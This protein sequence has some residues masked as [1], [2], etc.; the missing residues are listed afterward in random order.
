MREFISEFIRFDWIEYKRWSPNTKSIIGSSIFLFILLIAFLCIVTI[1]VMGFSSIF[2]ATTFNGEANRNF[3]LAVAALFGAPFLVWRTIVAQTQANAALKQAEA[4]L[5][6]AIAASDQA[7]TAAEQARIAF[8][9]SSATA[10]T[11]AVELLGSYRQVSEYNENDSLVVLHEP[12]LEARIGGVFALEKIIRDNEADARAATETLAAFCRQH[13]KKRPVLQIPRPSSQDCDTALQVLGRRRIPNPG[14][15]DSFVVELSG[16]DLRSYEISDLTFDRIIFS[17][18]IFG[19]R[20]QADDCR[21]LNCIFSGCT[22]RDAQF[23]DCDFRGSTVVSCKFENTR[24]INCLGP[25]GETLV[26][27]PEIPENEYQSTLV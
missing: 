21:F 20:D 18:S 15:S 17:D 23:E 1:L 12:N 27:D 14:E 13:M 10:F 3:I 6:Q 4:S 7:K 22:F 11:K 5:N 25:K 9:V 2:G 8:N 16:I 24:F 19:G 26:D